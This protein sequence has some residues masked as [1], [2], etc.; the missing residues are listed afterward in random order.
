WGRNHQTINQRNLNSYLLESVAPFRRR[1]FFTG[2]IEL[3][4]K[5]ELFND[6]PEFEGRTFRIAAY[7]VGYT[8]DIGMFHNVETGIGANFTAYAVP[9]AMQPF[10]GS[11]PVS[12][13]LFA[14]L[15]LK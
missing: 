3:V 11:H 8:R 7:T 12:V 10:Y 13:N 14:R 4:D 5:D 2:R 9:A 1:N 15:R 6:Q